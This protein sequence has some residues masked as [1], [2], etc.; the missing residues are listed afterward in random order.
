MDLR[1]FLLS[2]SD[3]FANARPRWSALLQRSVGANVFMSFEWLHSWWVAYRPRAELRIAIVES[4]EGTTLGIAP[5]MLSRE[6]QAGV[7]VRV[8]RFIGDGSWETD[9]M[10]F[11]I[12]EDAVAPVCNAL[13]GAVEQMSWDIACLNQ[14]PER[15]AVTACVMQ[16]SQNRLWRR[17]VEKVPCP[18]TRLPSDHAAL[19]KTLAPRFRTA[20]RASKRRLEEHHQIEFG[21]HGAAEELPYALETLFRNHS[22]RWRAKGERGVF[23]DRDKREFYRI[24]APLLLERGWLRFYFLRLD[25]A[26]VAQEFCFALDRA[27]MLLQEGFDYAHARDNVGN[28]LRARVMEHLMNEG[29]SEYDFLAGTSRHKQTWSNDTTY[30]LRLRIVRPTIRG[31]LHS[32]LHAASTAVRS[33]AHGTPPGD[34]ST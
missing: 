25:G 30:D 15:S 8:L 23:E 3:A 6:R 32:I 11:L 19:L 17:S 20:L 7:P 4:A 13:S 26:I 31:R 18:R 22:S 24:L 29:A 1:V 5:L 27:V 21:T 28:I 2:E 12:H 10:S 16:W 14:M 33:R 9:H 34:V